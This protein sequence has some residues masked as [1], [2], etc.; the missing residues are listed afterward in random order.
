M[1]HPF[2]ISGHIPPINKHPE[3]TVGAL[4][5][6][7]GVWG[8]HSYARVRSGAAAGAVRVLLAPPERGPAPALLDVE[9][10][11]RAPVAPG[12][13]DPPDPPFGSE[14]DS[15]GDDDDDEDWEARVASG[16]PHADHARLAADAIEALRRVRLARL[17]RGRRDERAAI[18]AEAA[19]L[20]RALAPLWLWAGAG[21]AEARPGPWLHAT[22]EAYAPV[23][24]RREYARLV[25]E[26]RRA[27]PRLAE[28]LT[29]AGRVGEV[30]R[31]PA[32]PRVGAAAPGPW[33]AWAGGGRWAGAGAL[34]GRVHVRALGGE[35][36]PTAAPDVWCAAVAGSVRAAFADVLAEAGDRPVIVG[37][38][39]W[40]ASV[41]RALLSGSGAGK[42]VRGALLLGPA[43]LTAE[44]SREPPAPRDHTRVL[45][46]VGERAPHSGRARACADLLPG[47][48]GVTGTG[49]G[50]APAR[51]L[52]VAGAD[53]Q[54][55]L[56]ALTLRRK[57]LTQRALDAAIVEECVRWIHD[58]CDACDAPEPSA[59]T[60]TD[61]HAD[62]FISTIGMSHALHIH[63]CR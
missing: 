9:S 2:G 5:A 21:A 38:C 25:A 63:I 31:A 30:G 48:T 15:A 18:A 20:R 17:A 33:V 53:D 51:V 42:N 55:R 46:V 47:V 29:G 12:E 4:D 62:T 19:R 32:P 36:A 58:A 3:N 22:L 40:G 14:S 24:V 27:A 50:A 13:D 39:G 28:R 35:G 1:L 60:H 57:G 26:L 54:L 52:V 11:D 10:V 43:L 49:G 23:S 59:H 45:M 61:L 44:G 41:A 56:P 34:G 16:A 37:G 6:R 7:S 8:E